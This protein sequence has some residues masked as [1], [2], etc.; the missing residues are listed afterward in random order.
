ML[1]QVEGQNKGNGKV[2]LE[3]FDSLR[4]TKII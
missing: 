4:L 3:T 2:N 1:L